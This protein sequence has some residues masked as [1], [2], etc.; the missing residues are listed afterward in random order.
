M[1]ISM[2]LRLSVLTIACI[3][4]AA[5]A[6]LASDR[7]EGFHYLSPEEVKGRIE[8]NDA[9][10]IVDI[11]VEDEFARHH[12]KG[13]VPTFA[14]PVK[15]ETDIAKLNPV[16]GDLLENGD[17]VLIVCPRGGGGARRTYQHLAE[18]GVDGGR[19][20]ILE[21]GQSGWPYPELLEAN[22]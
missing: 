21:K 2:S 14:Y 3:F 10:T 12:L 17:P 18:R 8:A 5:G 16:I 1:R 7:V 6:A 11:Q 22:R 20:F 4:L 9:M 13:A 19:L 15:S